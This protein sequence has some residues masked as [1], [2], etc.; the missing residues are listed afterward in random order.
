MMELTPA[1]SEARGL[2]EVS[3]RALLLTLI[4]IKLRSFGL[5]ARDA[6]T[7]EQCGPRF[8]DLPLPR[9]GHVRQREIGD[10]GRLLAELRPI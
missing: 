2:L 4:W 1:K 8:A 3:P 5:A 6:D 10:P 9:E 7:F